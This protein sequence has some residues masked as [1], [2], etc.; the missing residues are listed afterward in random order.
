M[1]RSMFIY[2]KDFSEASLSS[3]EPSQEKLQEQELSR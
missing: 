1:C 2:L 3:T